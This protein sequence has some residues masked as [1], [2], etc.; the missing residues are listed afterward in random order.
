MKKKLHKSFTQNAH[1]KLQKFRYKVSS[2]LYI[3][4]NDDD[5]VPYM[6]VKDEMKVAG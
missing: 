6:N 5:S 2:I 4:D 1:A 3:Q